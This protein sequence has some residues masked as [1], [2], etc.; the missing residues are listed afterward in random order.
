[1]TAS[2]VS[3]RRV[4]V[5]GRLAARAT[6]AAAL[7]AVVIAGGAIALA[8]SAA[9]HGYLVPGLIPAYADWI[10]GPLAGLARPASL[11]SVLD[12]LA[13][14]AVAYGCV[15]AV[16]RRLPLRWVVAAVLAAHAIFL[17][18]PPLLSTDVFNYVD[19]A[20]L[21]AAHH[22]NPYLHA[23]VSA[24][25][26]PVYPFIRWRRAG[27]VYGPLFTL[28]IWPLGLMSPAGAV[29]ALKVVATVASLGCTALVWWIARRL[30]RP[31]TLAVAAF[32]LN[33]VLLVWT[34]GGAHNDLLMLVMLLGGIALVVAGRCIGG[35]AMLVAAAAIKASAGLALPFLLFA[36]TR[37]LR[38]AAGVVLGASLVAVI[39]A[40]GFSDHATTMVSNL[41]RQQT[42]VGFASVPAELA[43]LAGAATVT[44][45]ER[46]LLHIGLAATLLGLMIWVLRG[47]DPLAATG[48][49]FLA[50][51]LT[52]TWL[53]G[54]YTVWPLAFAALSRDRRLLVATCAL[55]LCFVAT[56]I[57]VA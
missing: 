47:G 55:Q 42:L 2:T 29:W 4:A 26:D 25:H 50:V 21:E 30:G 23:P 28:G 17:L 3:P 37:R 46:Q 27:A 53:L 6:G 38:I 48:W 12:E 16:A 19:S 44:A 52:S 34:V 32:G 5:R 39:A 1:M 36:G 7:A 11:G 54:W 8:A 24:A 49:A 51:D 40:L 56:H 41:Q 20:R 18:A 10:P 13:V 45:L 22:L 9:D 35:G 14:M 31:V 57:P 33:P 43:H 15:L